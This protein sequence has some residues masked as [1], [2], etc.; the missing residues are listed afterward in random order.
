M[1]S[2]SRVVL[3]AIC[4]I[5]FAAIWI[6]YSLSKVT[7]LAL[8]NWSYTVGPPITLTM[9]PRSLPHFQHIVQSLLN[10]C[11]FG[12]HFK[13]H[14]YPHITHIIDVQI[15]AMLDEHWFTLT[16]ACGVGQKSGYKVRC[17]SS[18]LRECWLVKTAR[19]SIGRQEYFVVRLRK[20][21]G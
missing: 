4:L 11:L 13:I 12:V 16:N 2:K 1:N 21:T 20:R 5:I 10:T 18:T 17:L 9:K 8:I 7:I 3:V 14:I 6:S 15:M 19:N